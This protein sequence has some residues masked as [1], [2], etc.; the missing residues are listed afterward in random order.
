MVEVNIELREKLS[1]PICQQ[2]RLTAIGKQ[3][4]QI[5]ICKSSSQPTISLP[6]QIS[7]GEANKFQCLFQLAVAIANNFDRHWQTYQ[8]QLKSSY[9]VG[10][11]SFSNSDY[12]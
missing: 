5:I 2:I 7:I 9:S 1:W 10:Q 4:I 12:N 8:S 3:P 6:E 11:F